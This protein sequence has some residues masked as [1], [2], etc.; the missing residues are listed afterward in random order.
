[1]SPSKKIRG[2]FMLV[3]ALFGAVS[4]VSDVRTARAERDK[5]AMAN[6]VANILVVITGGALALRE[7]RKDEH[8]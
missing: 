5:L 4:A 3:S 6:A 7:F 1:M 2:L 8:R